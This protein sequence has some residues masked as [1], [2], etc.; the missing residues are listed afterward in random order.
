MVPGAVPQATK[1]SRAQ[2]VD[3]TKVSNIPTMEQLRAVKAGDV[4]LLYH[5]VGGADPTW[6]Y[7]AVALD[8][9]DEGGVGVAGCC[10]EGRVRGTG[11]ARVVW[12]HVIVD[13]RGRATLGPSNRHFDF[14]R[15]P[16]TCR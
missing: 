11:S 10:N 14:D 3:V 15:V 16:V 5:K 6:P 2:Q 7:H 12:R 4:L 1:C 13:N 9:I 8:G